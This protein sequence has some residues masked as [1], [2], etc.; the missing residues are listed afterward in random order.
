MMQGQ[1]RLYRDPLWFNDK[2]MML[3]GSF[4][5]FGP[6]HVYFSKPRGTQSEE[7]S[8]VMVQAECVL[9]R[10]RSMQQ[11]LPPFPG[12]RIGA[13]LS[14][15]GKNTDLSIGRLRLISVCAA[16]AFKFPFFI[17]LQLW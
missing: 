3:G 1:A 8:V 12:R 17:P 15:S 10:L 11:S 16:Y 13:G 7:A 5:R 9:F 2:W 6:T 14:G 4:D